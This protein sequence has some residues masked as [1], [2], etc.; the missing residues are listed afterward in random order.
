MHSG[1][2]WVFGT[3][4]VNKTTKGAAT[5][6]HSFSTA[7]PTV[8]A[9]SNW[10]SRLALTMPAGYNVYNTDTYAVCDHGDN[11]NSKDADSN[12]QGSNT[13][14]TPAAARAASV[15][16]HSLGRNFIM[17]I[18]V[19]SIAGKRTGSWAVIFAET[20]ATTPD[21]GWS[22]VDPPN[23]NVDLTRMT[24][25]PS[26]RWYAGW[27]YVL[28]TT[29]GTPCPRAGWS[30]TSSST[31]CV[32]VYRSKSLAAGSWVMG[33]NGAPVVAPGDA[34]SGARNDRKIMPPWAATS[35]EK[36]AIFGHA[37][38]VLGNIN[39][40]DFDFCDAPD[41]GGVFGLWAGI[42]NQQNNPYFNIGGV[43]KGITSQ[44]WLEGYF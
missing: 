36:A 28:T 3:N 4:L 37:P 23:N 5:L 1:W 12:D 21:T 18:E 27:Y 2:L 41:M 29:E 16:N 32:I 20:S 40:S 6:V 14:T 42:A 39:D 24:A 35:A 38:Q 11:D 7:N 22:L 10:R 26:V 19:S 33:N 13:T 17:S 44:Q 9:A 34:G 31:L 30:N 8:G 43:V 25:C 15:A